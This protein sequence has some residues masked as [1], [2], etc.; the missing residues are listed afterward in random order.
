MLDIQGSIRVHSS[1]GTA[2]HAA[3][4][5]ACLTKRAAHNT[6]LATVQLQGTLTDGKQFDASYDRGEPFSFRLG[7]GMVIK[8]G[9]QPNANA[10]S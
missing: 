10:R 2:A 4:C 6:T 3:S 1:R 7:Q 5:H 9:W 8:G